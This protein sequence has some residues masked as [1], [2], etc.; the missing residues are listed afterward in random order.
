MKFEYFRCKRRK[1][2]R[3]PNPSRLSTFEIIQSTSLNSINL[4]VFHYFDDDSALKES[5]YESD[6]QLVFRR[7]AEAEATP[8]D[9]HDQRVWYRD[10]QRGG[11]VPLHGLRKPQPNKTPGSPTIPPL[12]RQKKVAVTAARWR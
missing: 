12:K 4:D 11:E 5:G 6:S 9:P 1:P 8:T 3:L 2:T 10:I 7:R